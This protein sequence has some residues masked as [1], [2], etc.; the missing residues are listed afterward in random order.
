MHD[1][2][3]D[4][5]AEKITQACMAYLDQPGFRPLSD[6]AD[7]L[8]DSPGFPLHAPIHHY[9]VPALLLSA[10]HKQEGSDPETLRRDLKEALRRSRVV[11]GGACGYYG[12]CGAAV[13]L[14]IFW[15]ILTTCSPLARESW[16]QASGITGQALLDLAAL[17]GPRCC[18]RG[19]YVALRNGAKALEARGRAKPPQGPITCSFSLRNEEC[20]KERCVFHPENPLGETA[21]QGGGKGK[22]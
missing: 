17:G 16:G 14:G 10:W 21:R 4:E 20:L 8:M 7:A 13:G 3:F 9:L 19:V 5:F 6:R 12:S 1:L 2:R 11:P 18:K 15:C 22:S